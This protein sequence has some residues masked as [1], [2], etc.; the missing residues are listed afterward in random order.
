M[1]LEKIISEIERCYPR[2]NAEKWDN[3]GLL[4]GDRK[5]EIKK[6]ILALD[7]DMET[8]DYAIEEKADLLITHHPFIFNPIKDINTDT[9][10]GEKIIKSIKKDLA[11][12]SIHTNID[13][14]FQGLN[15]YILS[16]IGVEKFKIL[17]EKT[18]DNKIGIGRYYKTD[19]EYRVEEYIELIKEKLDLDKVILYSEDSEHLKPIK[20]IALI[21]GAGI[22]YW[23][24]ARFF[25][26]DTIITGDVK[27]HEA[28][29]AIEAGMKVI[30]LG[31][32]E[33]EKLFFE[34]M[35]F[36]IKESFLDL[37][38][39]KKIKPPIWRVI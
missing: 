7:A 22:S 39:I 29:D 5:R 12:Y 38:I 8:I 21:N 16:K 11:I 27:Y 30:D 6:I 4:I 19:K 18:E 32:Y 14:S 36:K 1:I 17:D 35:E 13:S 23:K 9:L 20:K 34:L 31:H 28:L 10:L 2:K 37:L 15:E 24:K 3:V 33:S 26:C 25:G